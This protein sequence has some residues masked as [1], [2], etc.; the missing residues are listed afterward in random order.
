MRSM[1]ILLLAVLSVSCGQEQAD[2][3]E[4]TGTDSTG[5]EFTP[6]SKQDKWKADTA[7]Y[8]YQT[9]AKYNFDY[10]AENYVTDPDAVL[11]LKN[12]W[13]LKADSFRVKEVNDDGVVMGFSRFCY[14]ELDVQVYMVQRGQRYYVEFG[15]TMREQMRDPAA[16]QAKPV[17]QY[18]YDFNNQPLTGSIM[19]T[20]WTADR[21]E[22]SSMEFASGPRLTIDI[23]SSA[24]T[25]YP[26]CK[27]MDEADGSGFVV[28]V[29]SLDLN[30]SGGNLGNSEYV[31]VSA[32]NIQ[33][34]NLRQGSYRVTH[35]ENGK[36]RLELAVTGE[37]SVELNGYVEFT[38]P[39]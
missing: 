1:I 16:R 13:R 14:P 19:K 21:V 37:E 34:L 23:V 35:L 27:Y 32:P 7:L 30:G 18:C 4:A 36:I 33:S 20:P 11:A 24:C 3:A 31:T 39:E 28:G 5:A 8:L 29:S 10:A 6:A 25:S 12:G 26:D 15:R 2:K 9:L 38:L 17:R 22:I